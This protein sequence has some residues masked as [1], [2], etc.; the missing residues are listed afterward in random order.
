M[1]QLSESAAEPPTTD[2]TMRCLTPAKEKHEARRDVDGGSFH[3]GGLRELGVACMASFRGETRADGVPGISGLVDQESTRK[4]PPK[5]SLSPHRTV[6][7]LTRRAT[8][9]RLANSPLAGGGSLATPLRATPWP[10]S[11]LTSRSKTARGPGV[12]QHDDTADP[13]TPDT[14]NWIIP[15]YHG[16]AIG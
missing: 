7:Y 12:Q 5:K 1:A 3:D 15:P 2:A 9:G 6:G 10:T 14:S 11:I 13:P 4:I 16:R 8:I